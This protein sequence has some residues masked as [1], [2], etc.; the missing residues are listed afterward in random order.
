MQDT[1]DKALMSQSVSNAALEP[2]VRS[3]SLERKVACPLVLGHLMKSWIGRSQEIARSVIYWTPFLGGGINLFMRKK[4][5]EKI[6]MEA[7]GENYGCSNRGDLCSA[8]GCTSG[9]TEKGMAVCVCLTRQNPRHLTYPL[10][11]DQHT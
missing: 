11:K 10:S 7:E 9:R 4:D 5:F 3:M 8:P 2:Q 6:P 1:E